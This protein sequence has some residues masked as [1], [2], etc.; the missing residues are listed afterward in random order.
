MGLASLLPAVITGQLR[1]RERREGQRPTALHQG[2][3]QKQEGPLESGVLCSCCDRPNQYFLPYLTRQSPLM[4]RP[5]HGLLPHPP[6]ASFF[7]FFNYLLCFWL[8]WVFVAARGLSLAAASGV[9]SLLQCV[10]FSLRWLL[11]LRSM[12][13]RHAGSVVMAH[14]L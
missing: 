3:A 4:L 10:G 12:G 9:Y 8:H 1:L 13:S 2:L 7:F 6:R 5:L 11:L 14:G